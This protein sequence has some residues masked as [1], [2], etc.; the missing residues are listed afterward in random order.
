[1][2]FTVLDRLNAALEKSNLM[3]DWEGGFVE[4]LQEQFMKKTN[5]LSLLW[6]RPNDGSQTTAMNID[7]LREYVLNIIAMLVTLET[8]FIL[9]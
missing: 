2:N 4:S 7:A 9:Y 6:K 1:M 8:L 5:F 3:T